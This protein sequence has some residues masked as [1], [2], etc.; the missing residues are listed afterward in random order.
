MVEELKRKGVILG[1]A[2]EPIG[3]K[4]TIA[5]VEIELDDTGEPVSGEVKYPDTWAPGPNA[6]RI[7][8]LIALQRLNEGVK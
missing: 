2:L 4:D 5:S 3:P 7:F 1:I 8:R 6:D